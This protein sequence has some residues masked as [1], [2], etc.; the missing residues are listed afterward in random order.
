V[1]L[2]ALVHADLTGRPRPAGRRATERVA[3]CMPL[4]DLRTAHVDGTSALTWLR[5]ARGCRAMS[6]LALEDPGPFL[7]A[8]LPSAVSRRVPRIPGTLGRSRRRG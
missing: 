5:W 6:G 1:N 8:S 4:A 7:R 3:W 2:P